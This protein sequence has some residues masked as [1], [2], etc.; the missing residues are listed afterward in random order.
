[1]T[2]DYGVSEI[3]K[4]ISRTEMWAGVLGDIR[5]HIQAGRNDAALAMVDGTLRILDKGI[6]GMYEAMGDY[7]ES[8]AKALEDYN[9]QA[10]SNGREPF[11]GTVTEFLE[12]MKAEEAALVRKY[13]G[14]P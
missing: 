2:D 7:Q 12:W 8:L 4:G 11:T 6:L 10:I 1:V 14:Q 3:I 13:G 5:E 9:R